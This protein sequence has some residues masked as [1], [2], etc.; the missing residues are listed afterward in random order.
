MF[1]VRFKYNQDAVDIK[2]V[3]GNIGHGRNAYSIAMG[4]YRVQKGM[5]A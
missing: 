2:L 3:K 1:P 5:S 4:Q